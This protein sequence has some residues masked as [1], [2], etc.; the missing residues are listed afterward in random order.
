MYCRGRL[1]FALKVLMKMLQLWIMLTD[2]VRR[3]NCKHSKRCIQKGT[4]VI[5]ILKPLL[6]I[7]LYNRCYKYCPLPSNFTFCRARWLWWQDFCLNDT[8]IPTVKISCT[9]CILQVVDMSYDNLHFDS[10]ISSAFIITHG[11]FR[12]ECVH[13]FWSLAQITPLIEFAVWKIKMYFF[14]LLF[15]LL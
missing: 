6:Y 9:C 14:N 8:Y 13:L 1:H 12:P 3:E 2:A 4:Q 5:F 10:A 7:H 15:C 11:I